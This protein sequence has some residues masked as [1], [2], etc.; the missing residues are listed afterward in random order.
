MTSRRSNQLNYPQPCRTISSRMGM[1][2]LSFS[3]AEFLW[4]TTR[5]PNRKSLWKL[6]SPWA[7]AKTARFSCSPSLDRLNRKCL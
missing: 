6:P 7:T 3:S 4:A 2:V 1:M 5:Q